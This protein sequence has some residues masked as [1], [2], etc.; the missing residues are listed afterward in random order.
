MKRFGI[1]IWAILI[2][3]LAAFLISLIR[4]EPGLVIISGPIPFLGE[5]TIYLTF[6]GAFTLAALSFLA[7]YLLFRLTSYI[8]HSPESF[9][10]NSEFRKGQKADRMYARA[11]LALYENRPRAAEKLFLNAAKKG[12]F[13]SI[14]YTGAARAAHLQGDLVKRDRYLSEIDHLD[15]KN[16]QA[17]SE[18]IRG[19]FLIE[20]EEY[21]KAEK[22]L[23]A[24]VDENPNNAKAH[25][26][27][28]KAYQGL[29]KFSL[30]ERNLPDITKAIQKTS[31]PLK[32]KALYLELLEFSGQEMDEARI[33]STWQKY[34]REIKQD[35]EAIIKYAH[36]LLDAGASDEAEAI[37][38]SA[39]RRN[40]DEGVMLAYSQ[41]Y[42]GNLPK[43]LRH[44]RRLVKEHSTS[45]IAHYSIATF[46][47]R[48]NQ[49]EEAETHLIE[50]LK[51]DSSLALAHRRLGELKL[52]QN[53]P[54]LALHSFQAASEL[55]LTTR[56]SHVRKAKGELFLNNNEDTNSEDQTALS[57]PSASLEL[58]EPLEK[59]E[60]SLGTDN[61]NNQDAD[62]LSQ[63]TEPEE[64]SSANRDEKAADDKTLDATIS[65]KDSE[66][67]T[68][69]KA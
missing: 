17:L 12:D 27:L 23:K 43:Q 35:P 49:L 68:P 15:D 9:R 6:L 66:E 52:R 65:D 47:I 62:L 16:N 44:V 30:L 41:L 50:A 14:C 8:T 5:K 56:P 51:L 25:H 4:K 34:P 48:D 39:L 57:S 24:L 36:L 37:L 67:G 69:Q 31:S 3:V 1:I 18:L 7:L 63:P 58:S 45:A 2:P 33:K 19:D 13:P 20:I 21:Q 32:E 29:G 64:D 61:S 42:R 38:Y 55:L 53:N 22:V 59:D 54:E 46:L 10:R 11:Q 40:W 26:L 28:T 60:E